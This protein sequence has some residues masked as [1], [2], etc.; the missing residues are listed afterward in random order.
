[1][2]IA[3][4]KCGSSLAEGQSFCTSCGTGIQETSGTMAARFCTGCGAALATG[5]KFCEKCGTSTVGPQVTTATAAA[6]AAPRLQAESIAPPA[7]VASVP[8]PPAKSGS[9][10]L[11]FAMIA[12]VVFVFVLLLAMGSCAYVAYRAKQRFNKV[13]QAYQKDDFQGMVAAATG[14]EAKPE[15]LPK[16]KP[17]SAELA[18]SP[19]S[20]VPLRESLRIV[21]IGS[22]KLRGDYE[23]IFVVDKVTEQ[24]VHISASQQFPKGD[25]L[26][27][28]LNSGPKDSEQVRKISCGRTV[29]AAD[30]QDSAQFDAYFCREGRNE[31][32]RGTTAMGFS[33]KTFNE[34]KTS[35]H[36][37][38]TY[39]EDPFKSLLKSFKNAMASDS[40]GA[41]AASQDLMNKMMNFAPT[42]GGGDNTVM[43]TPAHTATLHRKGS[44]D[45]AFPVMIN[46]QPTELPAMDVVVNV[47]HEAHIYVLDDPANPMVLAVASTLGGNEQVVKIYWDTPQPANQLEQDL[48]KNGRANVYNLYFDFNS[49]AL[50]PESGKVLNEIA[51]VMHAHPEWRLSVEGH[52]DNI[53]GD[54]SNLEL[55]QHRAA[56]VVTA[57]A[58]DYGIDPKRFSSAGFGAS[59]PVETN[60]TIEGRARNRRVELVRQ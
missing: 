31:Q 42:V 33:R 19:G 54:K 22:D 45:I 12:V 44:S 24:S 47:D 20:K 32:H 41:D 55:S 15:P 9:G 35:G 10:F 30:L 1:M 52:T 26:S 49:A 8:P 21:D 48:E 57:L 37:D 13:E 2:S 25:A 11:K 6:A 40:K 34:L 46:D 50:R 27:K 53:G 14:D 60:D 36:A 18:S 5:S 3:C 38:F 29:F 17:A 4:G 16:W 59:R 58:A 28:L 23:S 39:H 43:D 7:Q 51:D 56:A